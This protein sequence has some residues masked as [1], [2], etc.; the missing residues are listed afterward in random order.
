MN[1]YDFDGTIYKGDST[2]DFYL[3]ILFRHPSALFDIPAAL[4]SFIKYKFRLCTKKEFKQ[5][6]FSFLRRIPEIDSEVAYFWSKNKRKIKDFYRK[7]Q[8][9]DDLIISASP[10]FLLAPV[11]RNL[12]ASKVDPKTGIFHGEN[13]RG[14]EKVRRFQVAYGN[15]IRIENFYSDSLSDAPLAELSERAFTV[16]GNK[17]TEWR[18]KNETN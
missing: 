12:I 15:D 3:F 18:I 1:V 4:S 2:L 5:T 13:C 9:P 14:T 8:K 17:I 16:K 6:F 7:R 11:C 10:E